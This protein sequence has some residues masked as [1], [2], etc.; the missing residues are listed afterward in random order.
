MTTDIFI[1]SCPDVFSD[2]DIVKIG[3]SGR[4]KGKLAVASF[5]RGG[6][7]EGSV[8]F[9]LEFLFDLIKRKYPRHEF[10]LFVT[11]STW[12]K[13][14]RVVRYRGLWGSLKFRGFELKG[15]DLE[16]EFLVDKDGE[17]KF[18]CATR[19]SRISLSDVVKLVLEE[20]CSYVLAVPDGFD[21][22]C[23]LRIGWSGVVQDD[24]TYMEYVAFSGGVVL[25]PLGEFDDP[26]SGF[27]CFG[28]KMNIENIAGRRSARI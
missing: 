28:N 5:L 19:L 1:K 18:F 16:Q 10:W 9:V 17:V 15:N 2:N 8:F 22:N 13:D 26:E 20:R 24:L 3:S 6:A 7:R 4:P 27:L 25:K 21:V 12:Q 23:A 11:N 14:T